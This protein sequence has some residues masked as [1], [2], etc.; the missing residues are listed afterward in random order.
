MTDVKDSLFILKI[1]M[2]SSHE[3]ALFHPQLSSLVTGSKTDPL[4]CIID[5]IDLVHRMVHV[6]RLESGQ[7]CV[8][9]DRLSHCVFTVHTANKKAVAGTITMATKNIPLKPTITYCVPL[10]KRDALDHALYTLTEMGINTIQLIDTQKIN[11]PWAPKEFERAQRV[12][13]AAAEQSKH[14]SYPNLLS[15]LSFDE[16]LHQ[17]MRLPAYKLYC[18]PDGKPLWQCLEQ[19]HRLNPTD[20]I[21]MSGPEADLTREEKQQLQDCSVV[22]CALTPTILRAYQAI[23]LSAGVFRSIARQ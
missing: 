14:F 19:V 21:I 8:L 2:K 3:F 7:Q 6:L 20:I 23:T 4:S 1:P 18:D 10:L 22:F 17:Y 15:P 12:I 9:F 16:M 13:I 11:R 5:D